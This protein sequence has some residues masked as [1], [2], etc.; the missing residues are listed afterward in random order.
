MASIKPS[1]PII[2]WGNPI[3]KGLVF[4]APFFEGA[5]GKSFNLVQNIQ[6][7]FTNSPTWQGGLYGKELSFGSLGG[8]TAVSYTTN[9]NRINSTLMSYEAV[10]K[11]HASAGQ[12]RRP[13]HVGPAYPNARWDWEIDGGFKFNAPRS[14]GTDGNW[15]ISTPTTEVYHHCVITMDW[16]SNSNVPR[17]YVDGKEQSVTTNLTPTLTPQ[18]ANNIVTIGNETALNQGWGKPIV[19]T[20]LWDRLLTP[21][22][23]KQLYIDPW[24]IYQ[25]PR[26]RMGYQTVSTAIKDL[27]SF[28]MIPFGR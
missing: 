21:T 19:Y 17:I 13:I 14:G 2:N 27:I 4:D 9:D 15:R 3:T 11:I 24:C 10:F 5:G 16:S 25:K 7:V 20:R 12:Y 28:G 6:G 8:N 26:F 18:N 23:V 1:N 22:E